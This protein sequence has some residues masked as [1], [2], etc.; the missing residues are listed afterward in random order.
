MNR[1]Q[2]LGAAAL[3]T[4]GVTLANGQASASAEAAGSGPGGTAPTARS[5]GARSTSE[6]LDRIQEAH[7]GLRRWRDT[8]AIEADVAYGGPF[9]A[10][11]GVADF[12]GT[13][14]VVADVHRQH[15]RLTQPSG[16]VI[17]FDKHADLVTVT[18]PD[19]S[20]ERLRHPRSSFDGLTAH[21]QPERTTAD[22][23]VV[24]TE[25]E[26]FS[27]NPDGTPDRSV[28]RISLDVSDITLR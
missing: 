22:G 7:G 11:K 1:R 24:T 19:G 2:F 25:H 28:V 10:F 17:E 21:Y 18:W 13:D 4:A 12:V 15:I 20:V 5:S 23:A 27:R 16:R 9:W 14:H 26:I 8:R 3:A 6:L